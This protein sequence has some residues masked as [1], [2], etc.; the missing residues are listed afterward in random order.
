MDTMCLKYF[1]EI[2]ELRVSASLSYLLSWTPHNCFDAGSYSN[3][4]NSMKKTFR[5]FNFVLELFLG[6]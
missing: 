3:N 4:E 6:Y 1:S 5:N 2:V